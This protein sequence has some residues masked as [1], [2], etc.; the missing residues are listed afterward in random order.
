MWKDNVCMHNDKYIYYFSSL[1]EYFYWLAISKV[2]FVSMQLRL[3]KYHKLLAIV[4][5]PNMKDI[6]LHVSLSF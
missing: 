3:G 2:R 6:Y 1:M 4:S 5:I